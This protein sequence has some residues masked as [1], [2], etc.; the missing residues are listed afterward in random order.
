MVGSQISWSCLPLLEEF[1]LDLL[2]TGRTPPLHRLPLPEGLAGE[3]AA[4]LSQNFEDPVGDD[5]V[6]QV[7]GMHTVG[8]DHPGRL[9]LGLKDVGQENAAFCSQ[10]LHGAVVALE[11]GDVGLIVGRVSVEIGQEN[12]R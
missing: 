5:P 9:P 12:G 2:L 8:V 6:P 3:G 11:N 1:L 4:I 7:V 10:L